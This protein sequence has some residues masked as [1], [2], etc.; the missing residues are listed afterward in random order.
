MSPHS[1]EKFGHN[2]PA[3]GLAAVSNAAVG[4]GA[5]LLVAGCL[6]RNVRDKLAIGL[7]TA[8]TAILLPVVVGVISRFSNNPTSSRRVRKQLESI[9][10][11]SGFTMDDDSEIL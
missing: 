8:G 7:L 3:S 5:G 6:Q 4:F 2:L 11:D 10:R 9:R 1:L